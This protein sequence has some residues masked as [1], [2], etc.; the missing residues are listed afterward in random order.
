[1]SP[2]NTPAAFKATV[3]D[4]V[5]PTM[6]KIYCLFVCETCLTLRCFQRGTGRDLGATR[7]GGGGGDIPKA[8]LSPPK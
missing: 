7:L 6:A 1:M 5:W 8:T 3:E 2:P 4:W